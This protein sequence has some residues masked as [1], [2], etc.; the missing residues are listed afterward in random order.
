MLD[1]VQPLYGIP[2][3]R[4]AAGTVQFHGL[5]KTVGDVLWHITTNVYFRLSRGLIL[6]I[7]SLIVACGIAVFIF[8]PI[9]WLAVTLL[10]VGGLAALTVCA[11]IAYAWIR[12]RMQK[13]HIAARLS[14]IDGAIGNE[15][16]ELASR[17]MKHK[18]EFLDLFPEKQNPA[19]EPEAKKI[20]VSPKIRAW[21]CEKVICFAAQKFNVLSLPDCF[22]G[23]NRFYYATMLNYFNGQVFYFVDALIA[24]KDY[25]A[26]WKIINLMCKNLE[27]LHAHILDLCASDNVPK[28]NFGNFLSDSFLDTLLRCKVA[29]SLL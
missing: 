2:A 19:Q 28:K 12:S 26:R 23:M 17:G 27:S 10:S 8:S 29:S 24:E 14:E 3:K 21:E 20:V 13:S 18:F 15:V 25:E 6:A 1:P 7:S 5:G 4:D 9:I 22:R 16:E 11:A